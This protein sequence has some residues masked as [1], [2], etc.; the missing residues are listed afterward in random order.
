MDWTEGKRVKCSSRTHQHVQTCFVGET[1]DE[2]GDEWV[3]GDCREDI[4]FV[5]HMLDL[6]ELDY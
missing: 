5:A 4:A 6:F 1:C 3:A 2:G